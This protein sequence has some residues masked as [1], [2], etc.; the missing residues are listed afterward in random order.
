ASVPL[1]SDSPSA[2]ET[3]ALL[4]YF[5]MEYVDGLNLRHLLQNGRIEPREA[6]AIVPQI[7]DALQYA[8]DHGIVH[9]DI[10][11]ENILMDRLGHVKVADFGLAKI[12]EGRDGSPSQLKVEGR[13]GSLSRPKKNDLTEA[14][15][16]MGTPKYMSPEQVEAPGTVDHRADIYALGVV[17]YQ[18]LT[19][20]MPDKELTPPSS[21]VRIDVRLDE[22]VLRALEEKPEL[23]YQQAS[24][25]KTEVET[26]VDSGVKKTRDGK[27][28]GES[29]FSRTAIAGAGLLLLSLLAF[30]AAFIGDAMPP[31]IESHVG[32][33]VGYKTTL[34]MLLV[35]L[36]VLSG[37]ISLLISTFL[38]W[39][40]VAKIRRSAGKL[41][42][43]GLAVFDGLFF[44]LLALDGLMVWWM[45]LL[46]DGLVSHRHPTGGAT[47][48]GVLTI[49][50]PLILIVD[51]L[52]IR[53]V[54]QA[55]KG[56]VPEMKNQSPP[57]NRTRRVIWAAMLAAAVSTVI[58]MT[59][60]K[61][62]DHNAS[63]S[64]D[65]VDLEMS[66]AE[67]VFRVSA[68]TFQEEG[69]WDFFE[70]DDNHNQSILDGILAPLHSDGA[71]T[72]M[73]LAKNGDGVM[74]P[75]MDGHQ[76]W[77]IKDASIDR[78]KDQW[79]V[80]V[81]LDEAGAEKLKQLSEKYRGRYLGVLING[82][83]FDAIGLK[84]SL[85]ERIQIEGNFS[86][87]VAQALAQRIKNYLPATVIT[88]RTST[89]SGYIGTWISDSLPPEMREI[90]VESAVFRILEEGIFTSMIKDAGG[91]II[92]E[93]SG[94]WIPNEQGGI[95]FSADGMGDE[96]HALLTKD[97]TLLVSS[98]SGDSLELE[99]KVT[100]T[101]SPSE[102]H[103]S[104]LG[105]DRIH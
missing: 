102:V 76:Q 75:I 26:I 89:K 33:W 24:I 53:R 103:T 45:F 10:K 27:Q 42:G 78:Y 77:G 22:V 55:V 6:L 20:E 105:A 3:H 37:V 29:R 51:W 31:R 93:V 81:T 21:K 1:A 82:K 97:D 90:G 92:Q 11:P 13:D 34:A 79:I 7:C 91:S 58:A 17:F 62:S 4:Y 52:I 36:G 98:E 32:G 39:I 83:V 80:S 94:S 9:R 2:S 44:P 104:G 50:I 63:H 40:S 95:S 72:Y 8:H 46:L 86:K 35:S 84:D 101:G 69:N 49:A 70:I 41:Y 25:L 61:L 65:R 100:F 14:G 23:R 88:Q 47:P 99:R 74:D 12:V 54:W 73:W 38:G 30:I 68:K 64:V 60:V 67:L 87:E 56:T 19:G 71:K 85:G 15:K 43:L 48:M 18:M 5:L 28:V 16:V 96:T 59:V 66:D 57:T